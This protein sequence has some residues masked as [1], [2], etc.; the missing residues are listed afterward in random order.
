MSGVAQCAIPALNKLV[1]SPHLCG[2]TFSC[3]T[4]LMPDSRDTSLFSMTDFVVMNCLS[5]VQRSP[6]VRFL[7]LLLL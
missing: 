3:P 2:R 7:S 6:R 5:N 1:L 4:V